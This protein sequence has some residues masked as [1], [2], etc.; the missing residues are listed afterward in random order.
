MTK[1]N[2]ISVATIME[3]AQVFASAWSLVGGPFDSGSA[4]ENAEDAKEELREMIEQFSSTAERKEA[5]VA[6]V[7]GDTITMLKSDW[8][9]VS[10][11]MMTAIQENM[12]L[13]SERTELQAKLESL[14]V[15]GQA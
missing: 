12:R 2:T 1:E 11:G 9:T 7:E 10:T 5:A 6:A 3:Q 4:L 15:G 13:L 8:D 14:Q